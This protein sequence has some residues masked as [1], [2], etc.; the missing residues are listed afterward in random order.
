MFGRFM[1]T[2]GKFFELFNAHAKYIV[3]GG[4]ELELLIDNLADAEIHK[5]NVQT[6]EKAADKL[7]HEAIDLLHK[8][9][10]TPLDRDEIHKLI[11]TMDDVL[12]LMEDV[13]TAV[14]LYDVRAVTSEA[15]QLAHIV[16]QSAQHVQQAVSMLS[17]MKQSAQI[18]KA[19]EE[20]DRWE[21]EADRVL[22][23]AMS[24]LFREEDDVK[25]LIKLKAIYELLEEITDKCEDVANIIEGIVL[26]NA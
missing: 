21:S 26:E 7:T 25:T 13:A 16:T 6:A 22:R 10:I 17:D 9:F 19:C 5:Q 3:A 18:L 15:S 20:I 23:A 11:T 1:P 24:K 12:D 2:E 4:R 8:T 14:S